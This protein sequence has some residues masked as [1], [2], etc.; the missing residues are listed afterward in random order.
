MP[1]SW[2]LW[3]PNWADTMRS[4]HHTSSYALLVQIVRFLLRRLRILRHMLEIQKAAESIGMSLTLHH[5]QRRLVLI[6]L[7]MH[8]TRPYHHLV[9]LMVLLAL[10]IML[11][12]QLLI[13]LLLLDMCMVHVI[14]MMLGM[15]GTILHLLVVMLILEHQV[16]FDGEVLFLFWYVWVERVYDVEIFIVVVFLHAGCSLCLFCALLA[17]VSGCLSERCSSS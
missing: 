2:W 6:A 8:R 13:V 7:T 9:R 12:L 5:L 15:F 4:M 17:V 3:N 10:Q 1:K 16:R 11:V 14:S